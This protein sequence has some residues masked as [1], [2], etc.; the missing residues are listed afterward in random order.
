MNKTTSP[1]KSDSGRHNTINTLLTRESGLCG[2]YV[3]GR[4]TG[5]R[6]GFRFDSGRS[7]LIRLKLCCLFAG[8]L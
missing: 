7:A 4:L 5:S 8:G 2:M 6:P 1:W 3:N